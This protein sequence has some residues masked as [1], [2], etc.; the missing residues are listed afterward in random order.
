MHTSDFTAASADARFATTRYDAFATPPHIVA[1]VIRVP[2]QRQTPRHREIVLLH[3]DFAGDHIYGIGAEH[4]AAKEAG[5]EIQL[6]GE[7]PS[8]LP[9][10]KGLEQ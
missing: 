2:Y 6:V 10:T 5:I 7:R 3:D 8:P 1:C 9:S 4:R